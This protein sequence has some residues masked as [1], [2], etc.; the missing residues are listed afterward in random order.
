MSFLKPLTIR[1][2]EAQIKYLDLIARTRGQ[3]RKELFID[4]VQCEIHRFLMT[5]EG[6]IAQQTMLREELNHGMD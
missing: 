4:I 1:L 5:D 6:K 3:T 2:S